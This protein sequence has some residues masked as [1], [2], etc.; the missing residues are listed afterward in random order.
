MNDFN[1]SKSNKHLNKLRFLPYVTVGFII[2]YLNSST[3]LNYLF[4]SYLVLI[5]AQFIIILIYFLKAKVGHQRRS[6]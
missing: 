5:E 1:L 4:K 2:F 3:S 6:L